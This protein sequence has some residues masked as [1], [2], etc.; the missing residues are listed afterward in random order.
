MQR[1]SQPA[2]EG[3]RRSTI[4][5][6]EDSP[7]QRVMIAR[8]LEDAFDVELIESGERLLERMFVDPLPD[9]LLLDWELPGV[10]G[11]EACQFIRQRFDETTVPIL[12]LSSR[13]DDGDI[14]AGLRAGANDY[15]TK[16]WRKA[17]LRARVRSLARVRD[18]AGE[19]ERR[20]AFEQHLIGIVSHDLRGPMNSIH[21]ASIV[22]ADEPLSAVGAGAVGRIAAANARATRMVNDL[23]DFTA[24][25]LGGGL[26]VV[27]TAADLSVAVA[28]AILELDGTHTRSVLFRPQGDTTGLWD[29]ARVEQLVH[30]L[31]SNAIK[32][33]PV[34]SVVAVDVVGEA[35]VVRLRV[36]N[37]GAPIDAAALDTIFEPMRRARFDTQSRS[38]G[39]GLY[40][41]RHI[42]DAHGGRVS[43]TSTK[44]EGT[45][46]VVELPRQPAA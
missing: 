2:A 8:Q 19:L 27:R 6:V 38:I 5:V 15:V 4:W 18:Q 41:V 35:D 39:L 22:L 28:D 45:T 42:V 20:R 23:L 1:T 13:D 3:P 31:L 16:P 34:G 12:L 43:V 29:T 11:L 40:I 9:V 26:H 46:F 17:E 36:H 33:S 44:D 25:R 7:Q 37:D 30:N 24:A 21:L 10:S 32:Y 14:E